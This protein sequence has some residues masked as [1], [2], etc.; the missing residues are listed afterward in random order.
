MGLT[1]P[2]LFCVAAVIVES[3]C[4]SLVIVRA[5]RA[6]F[7]GQHRCGVLRFGQLLVSV[8]LHWWRSQHAVAYGVCNGV[9]LWDIFFLGRVDLCLLAVGTHICLIASKQVGRAFM[10]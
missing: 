8:G 3:A 5:F 9:I 6:Y 4:V 1:I 10:P 2:I 7:V